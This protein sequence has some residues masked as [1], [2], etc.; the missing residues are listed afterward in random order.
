MPC[1]HTDG[2][3]RTVTYRPVQAALYRTA[4]ATLVRKRRERIRKLGA[5]HIRSERHWAFPGGA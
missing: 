3:S 4:R 5:D 1:S 2:R